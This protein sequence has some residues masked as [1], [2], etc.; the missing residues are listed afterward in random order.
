MATRRMFSKNIINSSRFLRMP[1][2]SQL[3][4]FHLSLNA[5][6]DGIVEAY[7]ILKILGSAEDNLRVLAAKGFIRV[8][9]EDLV[10]FITDWLENNKLR[11]DKKVDS[12]YKELLLQMVP[13]TELLEA[14]PRADTGKK[15]GGRPLVVQSPEK[16]AVGEDRVG[17]ERLGEGSKVENRLVEDSYQNTNVV[18]TDKKSVDEQVIKAEVNGIS[19]TD[20][21]RLLGIFNNYTKGSLGKGSFNFGHKGYR[22]DAEKLIKLYGL[23][24]ACKMAD[25]AIYSN[26][27]NRF[28][29]VITNPTEMLSKLPKLKASIAKSELDRQ[30]EENKNKVRTA[31]V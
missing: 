7:P 13:D 18:S 23:E 22:R 2:D 10:T 8:L 20:V 12:I 16:D 15:T 31:T 9:N 19:P 11:P 25:Q 30:F 14:K 27:T 21:N 26:L 1:M 4:Y 6:D 28:A 5:D 3:L 17:E 29:P 24:E